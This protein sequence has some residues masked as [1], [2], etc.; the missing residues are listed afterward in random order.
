MICSKLFY[1]FYLKNSVGTTDKP[2]EMDMGM[3]SHT[4]KKKKTLRLSVSE[5]ECHSI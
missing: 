3:K 1:K 5:T 2:P 4:I